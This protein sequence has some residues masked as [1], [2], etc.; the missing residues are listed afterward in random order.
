MKH[1][2]DFNRSCEKEVEMTEEK[3][4]VLTDL[5]SRVYVENCVINPVALGCAESGDWS[6][7]KT[8]LKGGLSDGVDI[9][10][11][12]NGRF[13]FTIVPTRGMGF[14]RGA[15]DGCRLGWDSPAKYPVNPMFVDKTENGGLGWLKGFNEC[16]V[17]CGLNSNGAPGVDVKVGE[18]GSR[19]ESF[20]TLHGNIADLPA[21][22]VEVRIVP[23]TPL[24]IDVTGVVEEARVFSPCYRL[25][26]TFSTFAG[27]N[28]FSVHD[29]VENISNCPVEFEMLYHCNFSTPFM[30]DGARFVAPVREV[31]PRNS[32]AAV[33]MDS[34][35][36]YDGPI[37][38]YGE[39]CFYIDMCSREDGSSLSML[40]NKAG[41][42]G[43][44][45]RFNR[46][47]LPCFC[48]WKRPAGMNDGYVT[49]MEP[50][51]NYPNLKSFERDNGRVRLLAPG[52]KY[53]IDLAVE[54]QGAIAGVA[55]VEAEIKDIKG[56]TETLEHKQQRKDW[57]PDL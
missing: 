14:W 9:I 30:E 42:K 45:I 38:G 32:D 11:V 22:Y 51:L 47:Q 13:S 23:G 5:T 37:A 52:E 7:V 48:L 18:D 8:R 17:R 2:P 36:V 3:K 21:S 57:T 46:K 54:V 27:S 39:Q 19:S 20:V 43:V 56:T 53:G 50:G 29:E 34:W 16:V 49:G 15:C 26:S 44:V 28:K 4:I 31:C 35:E 33:S 25:T 1:L 12:N 10:E 40:R 24:R 55:S 41:D 6:V